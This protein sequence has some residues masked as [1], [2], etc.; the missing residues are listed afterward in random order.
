MLVSVA[1]D[2]QP[3]TGFFQMFSDIPGEPSSIIFRTE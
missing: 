1:G 3:Q 2:C